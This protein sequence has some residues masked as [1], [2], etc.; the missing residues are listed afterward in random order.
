MP[1]AIRVNDNVQAH[2]PSQM[3]YLVPAV[4]TVL[5][6]L[7]MLAA[8]AG[9]VQ[10]VS[11]ILAFAIAASLLVCSWGAQIVRK[12]AA[13]KTAAG[14]ATTPFS[15]LHCLRN[16]SHAVLIAPQHFD[17]RMLAWASAM[18]AAAVASFA[19]QGN[20]QYP[21]VHSCWHVLSMGSTFFFLRGR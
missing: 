20:S 13:I 9:P 17:W 6:A 3:A 2:W 19:L 14:A 16:A 10:A 7:F 12:A 18:L 8:V 5:L 15:W 11:V 21:A 4:Y 1:T